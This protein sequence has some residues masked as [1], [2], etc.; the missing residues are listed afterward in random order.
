MNTKKSVLVVGVG[1]IGERHVRCFAATGRAEMAI[2]ET[3]PK[4]RETVA[5]KYQV[6][7]CYENLEKALGDGPTAVVICT[8]ANLHIPMALAAARSG[9]HLFVEKP[10]STKP[11]GLEELQQEIAHR[12]LIAA[13]AYVYRAHPVLAAMR[14]ALHSGRFGAP[15]QIVAVSGQNFPFYRPAYRDIYYRDRA[16]GGGAVQDALT[17]IVNAGEWLVGRVDRLVADLSHQVLEGVE[18]EDTVNLL[19]RHGSVLG[20]FSLNQHQAANENTITVI[21]ER[22]TVRFEFHENRWRSITAPGGIWEDHAFAVMGRDEWFIRQEQSFLNALDGLAPPL[23]SLDEAAQTLRV[24]LG[25]LASAES[26][27]WITI[28]D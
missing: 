22:G 17:H 26:G 4:L 16:T 13:V 24:N 20:C 7:H 8:P 14:A 19:T 5:E 23:C 2:C 28:H 9:A 11:D 3:N 18:V 12:G 25:I 27:A 6:A 21:C 10:L 1:S 15:V